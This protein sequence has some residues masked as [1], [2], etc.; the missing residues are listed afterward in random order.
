MSAGCGRSYPFLIPSS[1]ACISSAYAR[2]GLHKGSGDLSSARLYSPKAAGILISCDLFSLDHDIYCGALSDPSLSYESST[3][4][5]NTVISEICSS[6]P[7]ITCGSTSLPVL[8][9]AEKFMCMPFP[10]LPF[11]GFGEKSA[12]MPFSVAIEFTTE[13]KVTASSAAFRGSAYLKSIS[14]CPGPSSW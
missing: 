2:Y 11:I 13:W 12:Y 14:F 10:D 6:I 8:H 9:F 1:P 5:R 7:A 3:V 4:F